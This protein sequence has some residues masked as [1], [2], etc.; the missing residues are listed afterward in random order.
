MYNKKKLNIY[1]INSLLPRYQDNEPIGEGEPIYDDVIYDPLSEKSRVSFETALPNTLFERQL[2]WAAPNYSSD[3]TLPDIRRAVPNYRSETTFPDI[4]R[5][6]P[7]YGSPSNVTPEGYDTPNNK[8]STAIQGFYGGFGGVGSPTTG[9][10]F[11]NAGSLGAIAKGIKKGDIDAKKGYGKLASIGS[12][13]SAFGGILSGV[14]DALAGAAEQKSFYLSEQEREKNNREGQVDNYTGPKDYNYMRTNIMGRQFQDGGYPYMMYQE[15]G[16]NPYAQGNVDPYF[17][18]ISNEIT[19]QPTNPN[20]NVELE[21]GEFV[22]DTETGDVKYV[23][24][25]EH[26][27]TSEYKGIEYSGVPTQMKQSEVVISNNGKVDKK[28]AKSF[29]APN[30]KTYA[31]IVAKHPV[32]KEVNKINEKIAEL[33][34]KAEKYLVESKDLKVQETN[35]RNLEYISNEINELNGELQPYKQEILNVAKQVYMLQEQAKQ[36]GQYEGIK[37]PIEDN[38]MQSAEQMPMYQDGESDWISN[39]I[40]VLMNEGYQQP[41][42]TAIAYS[43]Y[44]SKKQEGG[45]SPEEQAAMQQQQGEQDQMQKIVQGVVTMLQQGTN[46]QEVFQQLVEIGIPEQEAQQ[47]IQTVMS[48]LQGQPQEQEPMMQ[49]GG[50]QGMQP[51]QAT[52]NPYEQISQD[53]AVMLQQGAEPQEVFQQLVENGVP[54]QEAQQLIQSV[55]AQL[56][57]Q[58]QQMMREGGGKGL[59]YNIRAKRE[60][61]EAGSRERKAR[62]REKDYPD[63]EQWRKNTSKSEKQDGGKLPMYQDANG[64]ITFTQD[65]IDFL[66]KYEYGQAFDKNLADKLRSLPNIN[67]LLADAGSRGVAGGLSDKELLAKLSGTENK[68]FNNFYTEL[69]KYTPKS[70]P[71][72]TVSTGNSTSQNVGKLKGL[73][74]IDDFTNSFGG[75]QSYGYGDLPAMRERFKYFRDVYGVDITDEQI[76]KGDVSTLNKFAGQMQDKV[77]EQY[78]EVAIHYGVSAPM[79]RTGLQ[80]AADNK[81]INPN[82]YPTLFKNGKA[83]IGLA[84]DKVSEDVK[85][86]INATISEKLTDEQRDELSTA[87]FQDKEWYYRAPEV[88]KVEFNTQEEL[89]KWK[90]ENKQFQLGDS[91]TFALGTEGA[92][93]VPFVSTPIERREVPRERPEEQPEFEVNPYEGGASRVS[94]TQAPFIGYRPDLRSG[95]RIPPQYQVDREEISPVKISP[96]Q[97]LRENAKNSALY[98]NLIS[99]NVGTTGSSAATIADVNNKAIMDSQQFNAQEAARVEA[100]NAQG[101]IA[102]NQ[103]NINLMDTYNQRAILAEDNTLAEINLA[104]REQTDFDRQRLIDSQTWAATQAAFPNYNFDY[105]PFS[106][107][108]DVA[109]VDRGQLPYVPSNRATADVEK[110]TKY[111]LYGTG[112]PESI[113]D[114]GP[115][116]GFK[117]KTKKKKITVKKKKK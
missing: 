37:P 8:K 105:N 39:K 60:R 58:T 97:T 44:N 88:R 98:G 1:R 96:E 82:D 112:K 54:E 42:A 50:M 25:Q 24:G 62:P 111:E 49:E 27:E 73:E 103:A 40:G 66:K 13:L 22:I 26:Q 18:A 61:M 110:I 117:K 2:K 16:E 52:Q 107:G 51:M 79:T 85:N 17:Q 30:A 6:V 106:R 36:T 35:N 67:E 3:T 84:S 92:Y 65:E 114:G 48:Q 32:Q 41:Q 38:V 74:A 108:F 94:G 46:P 72:N 29:G 7:N 99:Q 11:H 45:M 59:W 34:T 69:S 86:E 102:Q 9:E 19:P 12:G 93:V 76:E 63:A 57:G 33:T 31:Q 5:A 78:P 89:D 81:I 80:W 100:A 15:G 47:L 83:I 53:V 70:K 14:K 101:R 4:R 55:M 116:L 56:Q 71:I 77:A 28:T 75:L 91:D 20:N 23:R 104:R 43:M 10:Y 87:S 90:E 64:R 68:S 95:V 109:Y 21:D 115:L 113:Q